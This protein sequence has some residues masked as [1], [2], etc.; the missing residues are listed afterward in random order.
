MTED[1]LPFSKR[2]DLAREFEAWRHANSVGLDGEIARDAHSVITW[3]QM[4]GLLKVDDV[5]LLLAR[6]AARVE[7]YNWVRDEM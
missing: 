7:R 2:L 4:E 3:L 5:R 6:R 1:V